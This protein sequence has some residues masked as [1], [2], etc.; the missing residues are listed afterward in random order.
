MKFK[1]W[2]DSN[3]SYIEAIFEKD[4]NLFGNREEGGGVE[5]NI[6]EKKLFFDYPVVDIHPDILGLICMLNFFPFIGSRVEFPLAVSPRLEKAFKRAPFTN[7]KEIDFT[8]VDD[9]IPKYKG[10]KMSIAFGGGVDSSAVRVMF[11]EA[12]LVH[13]A[14]IRDG[15]LLHFHSHDVVQKLGEDKAALIT[16]NQRYVSNPGGWHSWPCSMV[17]S[18]L[19]ATDKDI[20]LILCGSVMGSNYLWNGAKYYDRHASRDVQGFSGNYWQSVFHDIGIPLFSPI[21]GISEYG[22]MSISLGLIEANEVVYCMA[23]N[24]GSCDKCTKCFRREVLRSFVQSDFKPNWRNYD[25]AMIHDFLDRRPLYFG[26]IFSY[27]RNSEKLPKWVIS[28]I[29][30]VQKIETD[31][32]LKYFSRALEFC[33]PGWE[34]NLSNRI[35]DNFE[36]MSEEEE[37]E[38]VQWNQE[39]NNSVLS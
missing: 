19:V 5:I 13:E 20:G 21:D 35:R 33:P 29:S 12:F 26:H 32:P 6:R 17:T 24:G 34:K 18:L 23:K 39:E 31:W 4:D 15:E 37:K 22:S 36:T 7:K 25:T 11:P 8:N 10:S 9:S 30:D 27:A 16:T 28:R 3:N 2:T 14:H 1:H 38:L